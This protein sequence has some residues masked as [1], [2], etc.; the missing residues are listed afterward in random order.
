MEGVIREPMQGKRAFLEN[1]PVT[2]KFHKEPLVKSRYFNL[3]TRV[4]N[5]LS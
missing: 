4:L 2:Y 3:F 5:S 1:N